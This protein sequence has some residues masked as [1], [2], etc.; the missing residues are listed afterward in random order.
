MRARVTSA[1]PGEFHHVLE[2]LSSKLHLS[3]IEGYR[4]ALSLSIRDGRFVSPNN[5]N[6]P[7]PQRVPVPGV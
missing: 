1:V 4:I 3:V 6:Q 7:V 2:Q 5:R